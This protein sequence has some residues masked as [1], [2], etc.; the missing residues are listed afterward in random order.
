MEPSHSMIQSTNTQIMPKFYLQRNPEK[1]HHN[2]TF[3]YIG[4]VYNYILYSHV[5]KEISNFKFKYLRFVT[6]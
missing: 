4:I 1:F 2:L 5:T 6:L 3:K